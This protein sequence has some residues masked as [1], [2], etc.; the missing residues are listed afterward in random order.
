[1]GLGQRISSLLCIWRTSFGLLRAAP[2]QLK[3]QLH[4]QRAD[5]SKA[6]YCFGVAPSTATD[7]HV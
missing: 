5:G 1:M 2:F 7:P 3:A 6:V 4:L